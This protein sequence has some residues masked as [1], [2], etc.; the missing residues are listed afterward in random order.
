MSI[1]KY[2][3]KARALELIQELKNCFDETNMSHFVDAWEFIQEQQ[4]EIQELK[5][6]SEWIGV[7]TEPP[8]LDA[9]VWC[10]GHDSKGKTLQA[11][12]GHYKFKGKALIDFDDYSFCTV[13]HWHHFKQPPEAKS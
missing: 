2:S 13:T 8:P 6:A 7:G 12:G 4:T 1:I 3:Q 10:F 5:K 9:D 11:R